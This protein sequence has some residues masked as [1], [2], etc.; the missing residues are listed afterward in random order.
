V[1]GEDAAFDVITT[2]AVSSPE[3]VGAYV[4]V[5]VIELSGKTVPLVGVIVN[6]ALSIATPLITKFDPPAFHTEPLEDVDSPGKIPGK[7]TTFSRV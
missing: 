5:K 2:C 1:S 4:P 6:A 7:V 3:E